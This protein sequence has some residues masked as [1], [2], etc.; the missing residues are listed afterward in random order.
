MF[1]NN[2]GKYIALSNALVIPIIDL[3]EELGAKGIILQEETP[4]IFCKA[5]EDN[6]GQ[7]EMA[8]M[9]QIHPRTKHINCAYH[10]FRSHMAIGKIRVHV[11]SMEDQIADLWTKPLNTE[12]FVK[13]TKL[14]L[15]GT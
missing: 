14:A 2:H 9:P 1:V 11:I 8:K 4:K 15:A 12:L 3:L 13:L 6:L 7:Y 5:S 10:H